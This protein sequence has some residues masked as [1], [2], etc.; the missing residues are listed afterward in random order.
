[1]LINL[2]PL[3]RKLRL[4]KGYD[5]IKDYAVRV[6]KD[7]STISHWEIW[8]NRLK[9]EDFLYLSE[10]WLWISRVEAESLVYRYVAEDVISKMSDHDRKT[11]ITTIAQVNWVFAPNNSWTVIG[12]NHWVWKDE[13]KVFADA[14]KDAKNEHISDIKKNQKDKINIDWDTFEY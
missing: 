2:W 12:T 1:M 6:D 3:H 10:R 5:Q 7:P 11:F 13:L 9:F 8:R 14:I 4:E